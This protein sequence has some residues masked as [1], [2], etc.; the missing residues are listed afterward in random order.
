MTDGMRRW[1]LDWRVGALA[2]M[3]CAVL[4]GVMAGPKG[5]AFFA[6]GA[7][8]SAANLLGWHV[9][10]RKWGAAMAEPESP[11]KAGFGAL[12]AVFVFLVK[13]PVLVGLGLYAGRAGGVALPCFLWGLGLV[14]FALAGW[15][16]AK[17]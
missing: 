8:G 16:F 4:A 9:A 7:A 17:S 3:L 2:G 5:A 10:I 14:Y 13:L 12:F 1:L 15:A 11:P 6:L